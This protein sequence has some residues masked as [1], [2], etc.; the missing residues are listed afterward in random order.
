MAG[1]AGLLHPLPA[2]AQQPP[3]LSGEP[4][5]GEVA[6]VGRPGEN[7]DPSAVYEL[8]LGLR[9]L[10]MF[11]YPLDG[12]YDP[13]TRESVAAFQR[14]VGLVPDG[15]A[16]PQTWAALAKSFEERLSALVNSQREAVRA[17]P[18]EPD[19]PLHPDVRPGGYWIVVDTRHLHLTLYRDGQVVER[20]PV[21]VGKPSTPTPVGE[22]R[23]VH[24]SRDWGGGFG[25][26]WL[27]L[28]VPW[29]I[30]GIHG[31]NKPWSIGTR[32]SAGCIRMLNHDVEKLWDMVPRGTPATVVGLE[33]EARWNEPIPM[34][35][36][37]WN[38][39]LL[40]WALRR[41]G[42]DPGRA[43]GRM[44]ETTMR[45]VREAQRVLGLA[46]VDAA[47]PELFRALGLEVRP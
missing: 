35:V 7:P 42:F 5:C 14:R 25:T 6:V 20:W 13:F 27:G 24:K 16:G 45:A 39:P 46:P 38:V 34:G 44:G 31:T 26:R 28:D 30:Y 9:L 8:Q 29:G 1:L 40:Q 32:A 23:V 2:R 10:A 33:P 21:A 37:G 47:T 43:D 19:V 17:A 36:H 41:E 12:R 3:E 15:V 11:P 4:V 18:D 22:W